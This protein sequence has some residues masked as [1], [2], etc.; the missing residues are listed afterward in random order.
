M[1]G[2]YAAS[3]NT[4]S[5]RKRTGGV[6][7]GILGAG[8]SW[9]VYPLPLTRARRGNERGVSSSGSLVPV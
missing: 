4:S 5:K 8:V 7:V 2:V 1:T 3:V 9:T 6:F